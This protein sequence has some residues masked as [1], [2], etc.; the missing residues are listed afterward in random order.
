MIFELPR[1]YYI[2]AW[3]QCVPFLPSLT[4]TAQEKIRRILYYI[5]AKILGL[6]A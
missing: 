5:Y 2:D 4:V 3:R 1:H 6:N